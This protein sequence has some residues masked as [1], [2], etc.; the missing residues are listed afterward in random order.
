MS[1]KLNPDQRQALKGYADARLEL[2]DAQTAAQEA[3]KKVDLCVERMQGAWRAL[4]LAGV[5][6]GIHNVSKTHAV[7]V[8]GDDY[9]TL[10]D[11]YDTEDEREQP[12]PQPEPQPAEPA[13]QPAPG[14]ISQPVDDAE[15]LVMEDPRGGD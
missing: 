4:R 10:Q 9:P 13:P 2:R 7:Q 12:E 6:Y 8:A 11:R 5:P 3:S 15:P 14:V 1:K